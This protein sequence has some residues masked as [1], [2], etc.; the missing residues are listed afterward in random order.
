MIQF[1]SCP[2]LIG[3]FISYPD[4]LGEFISCPDLIG[5][6]ISHPDLVGEFLSHPDF[7]KSPSYVGGSPE[8]STFH[9]Y[10][11][12]ARVESTLGWNSTPLRVMST[13]LQ[14][15]P[16]SAEEN[17]RKTWRLHMMERRV[18]PDL[19]EGLGKYGKTSPIYRI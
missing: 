17:T 5:E 16:C 9:H 15:S 14:T 8:S 2:D 18:A 11:R 13:R 12:G 19:R 4:L 6:F 10:M 7:R 1:L 3:E